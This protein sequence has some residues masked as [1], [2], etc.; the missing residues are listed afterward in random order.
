MKR[1]ALLTLVCCLVMGIAALVA[2]PSQAMAIPYHAADSELQGTAYA[3]LNWTTGELDFVRSTETHADGD[4]G[5]VK[6][7]SGSSYTGTIYTDFETGSSTRAQSW[8]YVASSVR[9]V[10]FVDA[11]KPTST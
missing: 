6:S 8:F 2:A 4:T 5:T 11:V 9:Y 10:R 7:I 3:V 1:N